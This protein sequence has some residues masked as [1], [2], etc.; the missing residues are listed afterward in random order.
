MNPELGALLNTGEVEVELVP[1]GTLAERIRT[2]GAGL[3]GVLTPTG[4][5]TEVQNG[6]Q[7]I[8]VDGKDFLLEEW[9]ND[10]HH[11]K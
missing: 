7:V 3:G 9:S 10:H 11:R 2:G 1:Q 4:L 6:K 8:N 5:G